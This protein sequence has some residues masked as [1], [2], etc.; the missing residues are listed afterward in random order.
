MQNVTSATE[1]NSVGLHGAPLKRFCWKCIALSV[2]FEK[3]DS[4]SVA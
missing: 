1:E 4:H 3:C 2:H